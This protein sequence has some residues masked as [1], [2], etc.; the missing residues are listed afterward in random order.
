MFTIFH[1]HNLA[2]ITHNEN[3]RFV[4]V[5]LVSF[6]C[7]YSQYAEDGYATRLRNLRNLRHLIES[8]RR[9]GNLFRQM[10]IE[11]TK[12]PIFRFCTYQG[13]RSSGKETAV[14]YY[15]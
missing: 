6:G 11:M 14:Q 4:G 12:Q 15:S 1:V 2:S 9:Q 7:S 13:K 10:A 8:M 3:V 5:I